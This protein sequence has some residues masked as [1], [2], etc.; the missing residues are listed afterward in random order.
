M[1]A[2]QIRHARP[3]DLD[4]LIQLMDAHARYEQASFDATSYPVYCLYLTGTRFCRS[5]CLHFSLCL[6]PKKLI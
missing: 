6:P 1:R 4:T 3:D 2:Y 5:K